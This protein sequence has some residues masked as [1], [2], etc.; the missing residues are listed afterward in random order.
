MLCWRL[1]PAKSTPSRRGLRKPLSPTLRMMGRRSG[2]MYFVW[3][4][5]TVYQYGLVSLIAPRAASLSE[6]VSWQVSKGGKV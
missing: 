3:A 4:P 5:M 2:I 1:V 6:K